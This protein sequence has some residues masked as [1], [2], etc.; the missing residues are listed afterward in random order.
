MFQIYC[1]RIILKPKYTETL[2]LDCSVCPKDVSP[3]LHQYHIFI[4]YLC[5][6]MFFSPCRANSL[7]PFS[8]PFQKFTANSHL[9]ILSNKLANFFS[10]GPESKYFRLVNFYHLL[11]CFTF[12]NKNHSWDFPGGA[13]VKNPPANVGD[14]GSISGLGRSHMPWSN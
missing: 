2:L 12:W 4:S 3:H 8:P 1:N 6:T 5:W 7:F 10:K 11:F 13:A 9:F 14:T